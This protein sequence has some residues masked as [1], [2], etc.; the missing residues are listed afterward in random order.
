MISLSTHVLDTGE[1]R[2]VVGMNVTLERSFDDG[3]QHVGEG[4]TDDGGRIPA[5]GVA[6]GS[7]IYRLVFATG[8]AGNPF[9]PEVHLIV[10][11]DETED[12]YHI[13]LL[14]SPYGYATYRGS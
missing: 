6:L 8:D 3:W 10:D 9:F 4:V 2:P 5:L 12:H 7:G 11:L 13:P 14:L 1:G